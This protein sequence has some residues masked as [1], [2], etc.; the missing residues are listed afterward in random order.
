MTE[1][2]AREGQVLNLAAGEDLENLIDLRP[3]E[4]TIDAESRARPSPTASR[5]RASC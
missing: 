4:Q 5:L 3:A 1:R 2:L